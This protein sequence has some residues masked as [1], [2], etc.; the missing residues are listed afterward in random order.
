MTGLGYHFPHSSMCYGLGL[1]WSYLA[2]IGYMQGLPYN[3]FH[4]VLVRLWGWC[5]CGP[6][7][8]VIC[9][10]CDS[11]TW[12]TISSSCVTCSASTCIDI[13]CCVIVADYQLRRCELPVTHRRLPLTGVRVTRNTTHE[14]PVAQVWVTGVACVYIFLCLYT[15]LHPLLWHAMSVL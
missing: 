1:W 11:N 13:C 5:T 15:Y 7:E 12:H 14:L 6:C 3:L 10:R 2:E 8:C 9:V 4:P